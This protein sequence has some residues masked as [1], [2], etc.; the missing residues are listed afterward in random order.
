MR[1]LVAGFSVALLPVARD[2][3]KQDDATG[4]NKTVRRG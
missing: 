3:A 4:L 2:G 1:L